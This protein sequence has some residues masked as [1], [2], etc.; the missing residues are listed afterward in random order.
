[1]LDADA[2]DIDVGRTAG[3]DA[4]VDGQVGDAQPPAREVPGRR[5]PLA[6]HAD[7][8]MTVVVRTA[9]GLAADRHAVAGAKT[10]VRDG[11]VPARR[12]IGVGGGVHVV[13]ATL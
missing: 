9:I 1:T 6:L 4:A 8:E 3:S 12:L 11:E 5:I 10:G 2:V 13:L 7:P